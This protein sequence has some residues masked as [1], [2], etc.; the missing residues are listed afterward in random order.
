MTHRVPRLL[1]LSLGPTLV[2][3]SAGPDAN[4]VVLTDSD[5]A[6][7]PPRASLD[8]ASADSLGLADDATMVVE[9]PFSVN[10]YGSTYDEVTVS[11]EGVLFFDGA[12]A[13]PSCPGDG[14]G[15]W[16]GVAA[17][18]DDWAADAVTVATFG[19]YPHRTWVAEWS[20]AHGSAGGDGS[21]QVWFLEGQDDV[22]VVLHDITFGSTGAD[23]GASAVVGAQSAATN[24]VEWSCAG[25]LSDGVAAWI[26]PASGRPTAVLRST[27]ALDGPWEGTLAA[28]LAGRSLATGEFNG[29]GLDDLIV[30]NPDEDTAFVVAGSTGVRGGGL[31]QAAAAVLGPTGSSLGAAVSFADLDGDGLADLLAGAPEDDTAG[32]SV[33]LVVAVE[34]ADLAGQL[35]AS[36]D[37]GLILTG[38]TAAYSGSTSAAAWASP[39]AG[40]AVG[41][42]DFDG[43]GYADL[44]VGAE[45]DDS[46]DSNSGAVYLW[47][48][49]SSILA[50]G[51]R[52]LDN[53]AAVVPGTLAGDHLGA[54]VAVH[55]LD[56]DA[57][58]D[59]LVSA[60]YA[61]PASGTSNAGRVFALLG[62]VLS[63]VVDVSTTATFSI[64]GATADSEAG[65]GLAVGD[66]DNDLLDDLVVSAPANGATPVGA[67]AVFSDFGTLSGSVDL[68]LDSDV[69]ITGVTSGDYTGSG[70]AVADID[71]DSL[72]DLVVGASGYDA[73][74]APSAGTV[75]VFLG[76]VTAGGDLEDADLRI[77]GAEAG[78][79]LGT[80]V[81]ASADSD[82][83]GVDEVVFS[84][85]LASSNTASS[86][87][88]V[89]SFSVDEDFVDD[90]GDGFVDVSVGGNDCDDSDAAV[91]PDATED[92]TNGLDDDCDFWVDDVVL[93]RLDADEWAY[94]LDLE[95]AADPDDDTDLVDFEDA[96]FGDDVSLAYATTGVRMIPSYSLTAVESAF[97]G[98]ANGTL[99]AEVVGTGADNAILFVFDEEVDALSF[100]LLD[101]DGGFTVTALLDGTTVI[102]A[103]LIE[104]QAPDRAGGSFVGLTFATPIDQL[105]LA[106]DVA[107]G[108]GLDDLRIGWSSGT[109]R[110]GDGYADDDGD[111]DDGDAT[112]YPGA[113]EDLTNGIDDDCDGVIDGGST[114]AYS[115]SA[116]WA[117]AAGMTPEKID[118]EDL[119]EGDLVDTQYEDLGVTFDGTLEVSSDADGAAPADSLGA[120]LTSSTTTITFEEVQHAVSFKALD[121][122]STITMEGSVGGT[123][124]YRTSVSVAGDNTDGGVFIGFVFGYGID[125]LVLE[126]DTASDVWGIDD[127]VLSELGLDDADGDGYT[128]A[129]GDCDDSD[130]SASPGSTETWYDGVDSDCS[131]GSDYDV[132]G[133]GYDSSTYGGTDC[134]DVDSTTSPGATETWYDGVD[135]DCS[136]GSDYDV[137]GD[138]YDS[139]AY[140][141]TDCDDIDEFVSPGAAE[142]WYDGVDTDC[143]GDDDYDADGDGYS[144]S[145]GSGSGGSGGGGG[146]GVV[147]CDDGNSSVSPGATETWYDGIDSDCSGDG[148]FD[149]DGDGF[150]AT[151]Y[152]GE[153]CNDEDPDIN[154][155]AT[156]DACYDGEDTDCDGWSDYDCDRD[157]YDLDAYG[158]LDCD[159]A[160]SSINPLASDTLGDGIDTN[161]DGA[162]EFDDDGDGWDGVEDGGQDCDDTDP[163]I[164]P[165]AVEVWY[166][167]IDQDCDGW[168][169]NDA[170]KDGY[171]SDS[172]GG[173]DCDDTT[174]ATHPGAFDFHYDGVD[175]DCDGTDD[176][177]RD[178]DGYASQWYG[179]TD[180]DDSDPAISPAATDVWY[181]G[182]DTDCSGGS[183]FDADGDGFASAAYTGDDCDD[184]TASVAPG[185]SEIVGDGIDQNCDGYDDVDADGD[186]W[187]SLDDCDD[188]EPTTFPGA[189]DACYDGLDSDC[190]GDDDN[191]CDA[192][193]YVSSA[194]GGADCDDGN[195]A[196]SPAAT[197]LW[198]DGIDTNCDGLSDYDADGDGFLHTSA[199]GLDCDDSDDSV[200]PDVSADDCGN[201]DEDC[202]G[203]EDE[204]CAESDGSGA[205]GG[206]GDGTGGEGGSGSDGSGSD[207]GASGSDA[208]SGD[209]GG[210]GTSG[211]GDDTSGGGSGSGA[212]GADDSSGDGTAGGD[213][214]GE[215]GIGGEDSSWID[216]NVD[217]TVPVDPGVEDG[218]VKTEGCACSSSNGRPP[219]RSGWWWLGLAGLAW[220]A[221]RRP[222]P[223]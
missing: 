215:T 59:L 29:D 87:G 210:E 220:L 116:V 156:V 187:Y 62:G 35:T 58:D 207:S 195:A 189:P 105:I 169:D 4:G 198:Y 218:D 26:G 192:D 194:A 61:E 41:V 142:I 65:R 178:G 20:G 205:G 121:V 164:S 3:L 186:G 174:A 124:L 40:S 91:N 153:D 162:P 123:V 101:P 92:S 199:G 31:D 127:F 185:V 155:D 51:S 219:G 134:D 145:T 93:V 173:A 115:D 98:A 111:C 168:S 19:R 23:G 47:L 88:S 182:E 96:T 148:D 208:G 159:D 216:P 223:Q 11:N 79:A 36:S 112:V 12:T 109:D 95:L 90:D 86:A 179:G 16:S 13:T 17:F 146:G 211:T 18:W 212:G 68:V 97:G 64:E 72:A 118:F 10:W 60:P 122:D 214:D 38:P 48:G 181:D 42:G 128:E 9:L 71:A 131:G 107:D 120:T 75:A 130:A 135:T 203:E 125:T 152:G 190:G 200:H 167:G 30:G 126:S 163:S 141:G 104:L 78:A 24:G 63:G 137:D 154:P 46:V 213:G 83:D 8:L 53:A 28:Q 1:L 2:A 49:S 158:G 147:D 108:W 103:E 184:T 132:D 7:G 45:E 5:E 73:S 166:D 157:G 54:V 55:D 74:G 57:V 175:S 84:A 80:A 52:S 99:G 76:P 133:D 209:D 160:D 25:G 106:A 202:D 119:S 33:G 22:V 27:D 183:D 180:C 34:A 81:V 102:D 14:T 188:S 138:G 117:A 197:E 85:P 69:L 177:D 139:L 21:V 32:S 217:W 170:D 114:G 113:T 172:M 196:V 165:D 150:D 193:G 15:A 70:L 171:D 222:R 77:T 144:V 66:L 221:R 100:Q 129:D 176:Y 136:G 6:N 140:G 50:S 94:D 201:G 191:D 110:D 204:D 206:S 149:V 39:R 37:A 143:A 67:A 44:V 56:G 43:D 151:A 82:G 89:W 161:C